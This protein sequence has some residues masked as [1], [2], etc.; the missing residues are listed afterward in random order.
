MANVSVTNTF[1]ASTTAVAAEVNQNFTDLVDYTNARDDGTAA[2]QN[3]VVTA[4]VANPVK[5]NGNQSLTKVSINNTATD[6]DPVLSWEL[7][8]VGQYTMGVNDGNG[9]VL[10]IGT[11]A[12]DTGTMWQLNSAGIQN[13]ALQ[14]GFLATA[15][16]GT[17]N[18]TGDG[19]AYTVEY[20]TEI[21]DQNADFNTGTFT[22]AAPVAGRYLL[23]A[24]ARMTGLSS[25]HTGTTLSIV[26][27]NRTY[28]TAD[29]ETSLV[30]KGLSLSVVADMDSTDTAHVTFVSSGGGK[31]AELDS[32]A[33][34]NTFSGMLVA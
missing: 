17:G 14:P 5:F 23:C 27:S 18:V 7:G 33:V 9:D 29:F 16:G 24:Q 19:T 13:L 28:S 15:A 2:W 3:L 4:T 22:F 34:N 30:D 20:D 12:I 32:S 11:T 31:T 25:A 21:F 1:A 10:Q 26:T 6:G 8:G